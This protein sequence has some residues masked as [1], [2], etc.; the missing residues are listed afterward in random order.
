[1]RSAVDAKGGAAQGEGGSLMLAVTDEKGLLLLI[2]K[3][4]SRRYYLA[5][6]GS[7]RHYRKDGTCKHTEATL[8]HMKAWHAARTTV[9]PFGGKTK[10]PVKHAWTDA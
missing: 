3:P 1:M 4:G 9:E 2:R 7:K 10:P 5:C 8:A 6:F